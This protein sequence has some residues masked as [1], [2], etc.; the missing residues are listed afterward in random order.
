MCKLASKEA[1]L[2]IAKQIGRYHLIKKEITNL[3][4][5]ILL[6]VAP[7]GRREGRH[8]DVVAAKATA[9]ATD[10]TLKQMRY[11]VEAFDSV[12][13]K[14]PDEK[15][16]MIKLIYWHH[17]RL[18][19]NGVGMEIGVDGSTIGRWRMAILSKIAERMGLQ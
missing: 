15:Q 10:K 3:E 12:Y 13:E 9:L 16:R 8:T 19:C 4:N 6:G 17:R 2:Y 18:N 7:T 1:R 14:L 5:D 11:F